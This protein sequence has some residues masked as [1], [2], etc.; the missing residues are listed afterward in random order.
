MGVLQRGL[1]EEGCCV[2]SAL[3]VVNQ[4]STSYTHKHTAEKG[5]LRSGSSAG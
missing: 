1:A 4:A 2:V 5:R 3:S